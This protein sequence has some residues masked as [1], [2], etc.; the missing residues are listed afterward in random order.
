MTEEESISPYIKSFVFIGVI[1]SFTT[2]STFAL[3]SALL[4]RDGE[5]AMAGAYILLMNVGIL[6]V[7]AGL[8]SSK[9]MNVI[10]GSI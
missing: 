3:E 5:N 10:G 1:A 9:Y 7:F 2:F 6:L 4:I 8:A